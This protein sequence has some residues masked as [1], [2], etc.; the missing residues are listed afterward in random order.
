MTRLGIAMGTGL[1][2]VFPKWVMQVQVQLPNL[3]TAHN[4]IPILQYHGYQWVFQAA[5]SS[6]KI[7]TIYVVNIFSKIF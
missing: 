7:H 3:D 2:T 1:P 5:F 6:H 4:R